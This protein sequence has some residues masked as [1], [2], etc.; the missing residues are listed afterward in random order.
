MSLRAYADINWLVNRLV[1][2]REFSDIILKARERGYLEQSEAKQLVGLLREF[3]YDY[4]DEGTRGHLLRLLDAI[5]KA[6]DRRDSFLYRIARK[7]FGREDVVPIPEVIAEELPVMR[8][9]ELLS[10]LRSYLPFKGRSISRVLEAL[11]GVDEELI[12]ALSTVG[13]RDLVGSMGVLFEN[14][15]SDVSRYSML[16]QKLIEQ[17]GLE[18]IDVDKV[19]IARGE[20]L[21]ILLEQAARSF[22]AL[23]RGGIWEYA[24]PRVI[25]RNG[26]SYEFDAVAIDII[27]GKLY[28]AEIELSLSSR[29]VSR[30]VRNLKELYESY[31][32]GA[33][34]IG[35]TH[36]CI[37]SYLIAGFITGG[38][39]LGSIKSMVID[40]VNKSSLA[41]AFCKGLDEAIEVLDIFQA[42]ETV[43]VGELPKERRQVFR[44]VK[45][46]LGTLYKWWLE[47]RA[48]KSREV[49]S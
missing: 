18:L 48:R 24:Q 1:K 41:K 2:L 13:I 7:R 37:E 23:T 5:E 29:I 28:V 33:R 38:E 34:S 19:D 40:A 16:L 49:F 15:L 36:L 8:L 10:G 32:E 35:V 9:L 14:F 11:G 4:S 17:Y 39:N 45:K 30:K 25:V 42:S 6:I 47:S 27:N 20:V 44:R 22:L 21:S 43:K 26:R 31:V 3:A 12:D 46:A